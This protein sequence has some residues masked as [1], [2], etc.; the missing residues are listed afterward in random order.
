MPVGLL[1]SSAAKDAMSHGETF[2][3]AKLA[4]ESTILPLLRLGYWMSVGSWGFE[5]YSLVLMRDKVE[6]AGADAS[7]ATEPSDCLSRS[8]D[9]RRLFLGVLFSVVSYDGE[10]LLGGAC[11]VSLSEVDECE[12][13]HRINRGMTACGEIEALYRSR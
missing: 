5:L 10:V 2:S 7:S 11:E 6:G 8:K 12:E 9:S 3:V 1:I 13:S 4:L